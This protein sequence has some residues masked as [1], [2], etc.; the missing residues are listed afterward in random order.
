VK[1]LLVAVLGALGLGALLRRRSRSAP[2]PSPAEDLRAKLDESRAAPPAAP[3]VPAEPA[4]PTE[5][6]AAAE[7]APPEPEQPEPQ[8]VPE[9]RAAVHDRARAAID[10]L[11]DEPK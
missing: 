6:E 9:R 5:P 10:E 7:P 1:R 3:E 4:V 2:D 11:R 8:D